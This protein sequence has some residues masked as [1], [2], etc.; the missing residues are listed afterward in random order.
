MVRYWWSILQ[1]AI[2]LAGLVIQL[3]KIE[4]EN[5]MN[6]KIETYVK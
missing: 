6:F 3:W 5:N 1:Y 4:N 2:L